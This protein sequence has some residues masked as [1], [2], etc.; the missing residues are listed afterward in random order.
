MNDRNIILERVERKIRGIPGVVDMVFLDNEF[1]ENI[2]ALEKKAEENGAVGG[3][4]PFVNKGVWEALNRDVSFIMIINKVSIPEV[5][6]D[7]TIYLV[8]Q[9]G[10]ILGEY[11]SK[12]RLAK[13]KD[14]EDVCFLSDDF[15]LYSDI[16]IVGEPYFLIPEI[17]FHGLDGIEGITRVTSGS[18]STLSDFFVR[19]AKGYLESKHWTHLVGFDIVEDQP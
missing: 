14:R 9:K 16:E 12:D 19:Y 10:Q 6:S 2:I 18:I 5:A 13:L 17:E 8:D 7:H 4:M 3:L 1:K 15:V 11:V